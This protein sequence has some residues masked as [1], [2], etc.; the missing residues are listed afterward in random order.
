MGRTPGGPGA[1]KPR[2]G[3]TVLKLGRW[4]WYATTWISVTSDKRYG[5]MEADP[6]GPRDPKWPQKGCFSK[7]R[8]YGAQTW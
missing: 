6:W 2:E 3:P 7:G 8:S 4:V 5:P 1:P